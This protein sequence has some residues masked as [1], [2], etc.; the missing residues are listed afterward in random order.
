MEYRQTKDIWA[1][2]IPIALTILCLTVGLISPATAIADPS[3]DARVQ[4]GLSVAATLNDTDLNGAG[5]NDTFIS[6]DYAA[7]F[8]PQTLSVSVNFSPDAAVTERTVAIRLERGLTFESMQ[9]FV[10]DKSN[11]TYDDSKAGDLSGSVETATY[12]PDPDIAL[13]NAKVSPGNG[14]ATYVFKDGGSHGNVTAAKITLSVKA[15]VGF[16]AKANSR[17]FRDAIK[18]SASQKNSDKS[19]S[20]TP[21]HT[22]EHYTITGKYHP[23]LYANLQKS[24][25]YAMPGEEAALGFFL[26]SAGEHYTNPQGG[27]FYD[28]MSFNVNLPKGLSP[29]SG[30]P[31]TFPPESKLTSASMT[32]TVSGD[33]DS[34]YTVK[35]VGRDIFAHDGFPGISSFCLNVAV[36]PNVPNGTLL[37]TDLDPN[38]P[39]AYKPYGDPTAGGNLAGGG[40]VTV[41]AGDA[42]PVLEF[43]QVPQNSDPAHG[44]AYVNPDEMSPG[45]L[46][47]LT[48]VAVKNPSA[49]TTGTQGIKLEFPKEI[50]ARM[51]RLPVAPKDKARN[52]TVRLTDGKTLN[53]GD[54]DFGY[55]L[56]GKR[57]PF[58][59]LSL[60]R[61]GVSDHS[62]GIESLQYESTGFPTGYGENSAGGSL[63][64]P[65][66]VYGCFGKSYTPSFEV[67]VS[68]NDGGIP[69]TGQ[70]WP[71]ASSFST[72]V[73]REGM[74]QFE[75]KH[76]V[77]GG[78][79]ERI[80]AG[81]K[82][83]ILHNIKLYGNRPLDGKAVA[84]QS[85]AA[86]KGY[87]KG[88]EIFLREAGILS[89][90]P[91]SIVVTQRSISDKGAPDSRVLT[92][93][94][95]VRGKDNQMQD[96]LRIVL[97]DASAS[98]ID[99]LNMRTHFSVEYDFKVKIDAA[100]RTLKMKELL[101]VEPLRSDGSLE[102]FVVRHGNSEYF[103]HPNE[104]DVAGRGD[105][106]LIYGAGDDRETIGIVP[107]MDFTVL[108]S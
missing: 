66:S 71:T 44:L 48:S 60:A 94:S 78:S 102:P 81:D 36:D 59:E 91:K 49:R 13:N 53:L 18:V 97:P 9:G 58:V 72:S 25:Q 104:F 54:H 17:T 16:L 33:A 26:Y 34:G 5:N 99:P 20:T 56:S 74:L 98:G 38:G 46:T 55:P 73:K 28:E 67:K 22:L 4:N 82:R 31:I 76:S 105:A 85:A 15:H 23:F 39:G 61:E 6:E 50:T 70:S 21:T 2:R 51:A 43:S 79:A 37:R 12:K 32:G 14:E 47:A 83:H 96:V 84:G 41:I 108:T 100:A 29:V 8:T 11:Y 89:V 19:I 80:V 30:N 7:Q 87:H 52:L 27:T 77:T 64:A 40:S 86:V 1:R 95:I 24:T 63:Y 65:L 106:N 75:T 101:F 68:V 92:P 90:D 62:V 10:K 93:K 88:F 107:S 45:D 69:P 57:T 42:S 103:N 3:D 35:I